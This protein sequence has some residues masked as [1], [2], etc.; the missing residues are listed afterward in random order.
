MSSSLRT[1]LLALI[2]VSGPAAAQDAARPAETGSPS[3]PTLRVA[4]S[5]ALERAVPLCLE[6]RIEAE[7]IAGRPD[8]VRKLEPVGNL[9]RFTR[10]AGMFMGRVDVLDTGNFRFRFNLELR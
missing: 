1:A 10:L 3:R 2:V 9:T 4:E 7:R 5:C 8:G 6:P